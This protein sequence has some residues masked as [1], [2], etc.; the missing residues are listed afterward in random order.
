[1]E[2]RTGSIQE[3]INAVLEAPLLMSAHCL[4]VTPL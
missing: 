1:M 2:A 4:L 3:V